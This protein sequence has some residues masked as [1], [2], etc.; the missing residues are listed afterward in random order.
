M[1]NECLVF[2]EIDKFAVLFV[3]NPY[4]ITEDTMEILSGPV[5][6]TGPESARTSQV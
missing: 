1:I 5:L 2:D 3:N 4:L 6:F